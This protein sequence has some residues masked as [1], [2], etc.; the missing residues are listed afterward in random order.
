M[1]D[2]DTRALVRY[3]DLQASLLDE[4]NWRLAVLGVQEIGISPDLITKVIGIDLVIEWESAAAG[5]RRRRRD[6]RSGHRRRTGRA[7]RRRRDRPPTPR[8]PLS[9]ARG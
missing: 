7:S 1:V 3:T 5:R 8:R 4:R 2:R 6:R 9:S